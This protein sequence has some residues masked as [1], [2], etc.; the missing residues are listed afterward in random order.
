MKHPR[1]EQTKKMQTQNTDP[2]GLWDTETTQLLLHGQQQQM[3]RN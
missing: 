2:T 1:Q 3:C